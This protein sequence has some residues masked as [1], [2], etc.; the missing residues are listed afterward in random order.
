MVRSSISS[1]V[2]KRVY[3]QI[4]VVST[5]NIGARRMSV[6]LEYRTPMFFR[7]ASPFLTRMEKGT[8]GKKLLELRPWKAELVAQQIGDQF[9]AAVIFALVQLVAHLHALQGR[10]IL[11]T[12]T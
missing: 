5:S 3:L 6:S 9:V 7:W 12:K 2:P 10:D 4:E 8:W 1:P 11:K